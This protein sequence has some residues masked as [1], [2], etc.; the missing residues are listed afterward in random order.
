MGFPTF[1]PRQNAD[2]AEYYVLV[3]WPDG[4]AARINYFGTL[5]DAQGWIARES[6]NWLEFRAQT[7]SL[8]RESPP[9]PR[10]SFAQKSKA[11]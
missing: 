6:T 7:H 4:A 2:H 10:V 1:T 9:A 5:E 11:A 8:E 3:S